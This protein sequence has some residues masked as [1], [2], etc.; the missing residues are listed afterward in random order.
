MANPLRI[1]R[2]VCALLLLSFGT[3]WAD[4]PAPSS[5]PLEQRIARLVE[6]L[7]APRFDTREA[8]TVALT[9]IGEPAR[10]ALEAALKDPPSL[11]VQVRARKALESIQ[12]ESIKRN[13][14]HLDDVLEQVRLANRQQ[15]NADGLQARLLRFVQVLAEAGA[16][17]NFKLPARFRDVQPGRDDR[18]ANRL[19]II[20]GVCK[21]HIA[22][23]S[24]ILADTAAE[25]SIAQDSIIIARVAANVNMASNCLVI[26]GQSLDCSHAGNSVLLSGNAG[27]LSVGDNSVFG[28]AGECSLSMGRSTTLLNC[29]PHEPR[30]DDGSRFVK[31]EGI[32]LRVV[33]PPNPLAD[34]IAVTF[35]L[36]TNNGPVLF[37]LLRGGGEYVART[38]QPIK[39]PDGTEIPELKGWKVRYA[40]A[41][42]AVFTDGEQQVC[43]PVSER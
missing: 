23:N 8:A 7:D 4:K 27:S 41:R 10:I 42:M 15:L 12:L 35:S 13:G 20:D 29:R 40:G 21:C 5:E 16:T 28:C 3:A 11:E 14:V 1:S 31:T 33:P 36:Q 24:I 25:V 34:K 17:K 38:G 30:R 2:P 26:A 32:V 6:E 37:R 43:M 19:L 39:A 18:I 22:Q 9:E